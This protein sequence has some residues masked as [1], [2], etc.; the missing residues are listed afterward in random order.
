MATKLTQILGKTQARL[1][2]YFAYL[3]TSVDK[4]AAQGVNNQLDDIWSLLPSEAQPTPSERS[5]RAYTSTDIHNHGFIT[6]QR[7]TTPLWAK[8][9]ESQ[10]KKQS[11]R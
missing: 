10:I 7:G 9:L 4:Q 1:S 3:N 5:L 6:Q 8:T 2:F 11:A